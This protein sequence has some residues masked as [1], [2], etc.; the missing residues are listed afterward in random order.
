MRTQLAGV[1]LPEA[2]LSNAILVAA[3]LDQALHM[4]KKTK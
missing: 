4:D 2:D 3:K 1:Y